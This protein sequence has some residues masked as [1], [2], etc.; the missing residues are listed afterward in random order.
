MLDAKKDYKYYCRSCKSKHSY[1]QGRKMNDMRKKHPREFWK[2]F[3]NKKSTPSETGIS[4]EQFNQYFESLSTEENAFQNPEVNEFLQNF[5]TSRSESTFHELDDPI[6][7]EEIKCAATPHKSNKS[8]SLNNIMNEYLKEC[9]DVL[10][11]PLETVL[12]IFSIRN[13]FQN[14]GQ[15]ALLYLYTR[16]ATLIYLVITGGSLLLAVLASYSR[17]SSMRDWKNGP[18][19]RYNFGRAVRIQIRLWYCRRNFHPTIAD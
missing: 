5:E 6:M 10:K 16:K 19:K 3:K 12:T 9:I 11:L 18:I 15:K 13:H 8:C 1:D 17:L 14:N 4:I 7:Q 2:M